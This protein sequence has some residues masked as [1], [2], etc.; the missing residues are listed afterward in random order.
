MRARMHDWMLRFDEI[1]RARHRTPFQWGLHDCCMWPADCVLAITGDDPAHGF[2]GSYSDEAGARALV[3]AHGGVAGLASAVLGDE[4]PP[5]AARVGDIGL[6]ETATGE[7]P[8]LC[9]CG[10][11]FWFAAGARGLVMLPLEAIE[12]AWRVEVS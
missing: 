3:E 1:V 4:V 8:S 9:V 12:R 2:R 10:G 5:A 11:D 6:H 7:G